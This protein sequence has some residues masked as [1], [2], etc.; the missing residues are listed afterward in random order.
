MRLLTTKPV[1]QVWLTK[2]ESDIF[3][4]ITDCS[5]FALAS[6]DTPSTR[7]VNACAMSTGQYI[8]VA[9]SWIP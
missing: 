9:I 3:G 2:G 4:R 7:F 8:D 5:D 6:R 1:Q